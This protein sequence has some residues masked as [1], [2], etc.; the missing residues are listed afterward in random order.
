M[1][2]SPRVRLALRSSAK[3][4]NDS[5]LANSPAPM[6]PAPP[7]ASP[8]RKKESCALTGRRQAC[9]IF[10]LRRQPQCDLTSMR[11]GDLLWPHNTRAVSLGRRTRRVWLPHRDRHCGSCLNTGAGHGRGTQML[12]TW[13][14]FLLCAIK[15]NDL[16]QGV[17][18]WK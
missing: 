15:N 3:A 8:L 2:T 9:H 1:A 10:S 12:L 7:T 11:W 13:F 18:A 6:A 14:A 4:G 5:P 17:V 16:R